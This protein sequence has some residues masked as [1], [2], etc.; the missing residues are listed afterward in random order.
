MTTKIEA[1]ADI[2]LSDNSLIRGGPFYHVQTATRLIRPNRWDFHRRITFA[3]AIGWVPLLLITLLFKPEALMSFL[4]D[5]RIHSRMLIAVPVLL[6]GQSL[7]ESRFRSVVEHIR[8]AR[9]LTD[10]ELGRADE[11]M[12]WLRRLRDS[13]LPEII[14]LLLVVAHTA[15]SFSKLVD[16]NPW[17][18][19]PTEAGLHLTPAGWYAVLISAS[20][21]QFL[22]GLNLWKWLLWSVFAFSLSR[23]SLN[24]IPTHSDGHG[25]LGF[26]GLTPIGFTPISFAATAVIGASWRHEI[27]R[28]NAHLI[29]FKLP[30]IALAVIIVCL[31]L[32]P[33]AFF[34]P[35]LAALRRKGILEYSI[36]G[37]IQTADFHEKWIVHRAGRESQVLTEMEGSNVVDFSQTYD[38]VKQLMPFPLDR[39]AFIPLALSIVIPALPT[40]FAEIPVAV[41]LKNLLQAL[42]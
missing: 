22:L 29:D 23:L 31:A 34:V 17:L 6:F 41:A 8:N 24:L 14:I 33:L 42:H 16:A 39:G 19:T 10:T 13:A 9:L 32:L 2:S 37:Q 40:I 12:V 7:M 21:F 36:L 18:A 1:N 30:A 25:G 26:L 11:F 35:R 38:R 15:L 20:I 27:L 4:K 28:N 3:L 5:Y